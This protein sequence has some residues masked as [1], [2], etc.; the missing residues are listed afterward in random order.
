MLTLTRIPERESHLAKPIYMYLAFP[1]V[2]VTVM[3]VIVLF[4]QCNWSYW[5][6]L[7]LSVSM[8]CLIKYIPI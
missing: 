6:S 2:S 1:N 7:P 4:H 3:K 5:F 8:D